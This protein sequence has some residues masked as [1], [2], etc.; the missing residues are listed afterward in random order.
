MYSLLSLVSQES[1]GEIV[2]RKMGTHQIQ[3]IPLGIS[4]NR[5]IQE[6][7]LRSVLQLESKVLSEF[8]NLPIQVVCIENRI[9]TSN[10]FFPFLIS[11][12]FHSL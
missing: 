12:L 5:I 11:L 9:K 2:C 1:V 7:D 10:H 8:L 6:L 3:M 4:Q